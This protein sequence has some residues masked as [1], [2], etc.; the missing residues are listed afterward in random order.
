MHVLY[1]YMFPS[2]SHP[3][4]LT[5]RTLG[6]GGL[7]WVFGNLVVACGLHVIAIRHPEDRCRLAAGW[8]GVRDHTDFNSNRKEGSDLDPELFAQALAKATELR[9]E[10]SRKGGGTGGSLTM[11]PGECGADFLSL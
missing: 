1:V 5:T 4:H 3:T 8:G 2:S 9:R 7:K 11:I 6:L 10:H